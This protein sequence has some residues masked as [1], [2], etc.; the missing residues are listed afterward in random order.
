MSEDKKDRWGCPDWRDASAYPVS[1]DSLKQWAWRWQ[2]VRRLPHYRKYWVTLDPRLPKEPTDSKID[3]FQHKKPPD[4]D[5]EIIAMKYSLGLMPSPRSEGL[6]ENPFIEGIGGSILILPSLDHVL[7]E[8]GNKDDTEQFL[9]QLARKQHWMSKT[10]I[11]YIMD[12]VCLFR[13]DLNRD[14][15]KQLE[16]AERMLLY[17]QRINYPDY[18][19]ITQ[20]RENWP[21]F[22]RIIDA[23]DQ[24]PSLKL[25]NFWDQLIA[26]P[27]T[28]DKF[29]EV[30]Q[31]RARVS[32]W[33]KAASEVMEKAARLL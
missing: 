19:R 20:R 9:S 16:R 6:R 3:P 2:F 32:Q 1:G 21:L 8:C 7:S 24:E 26:D 27:E 11:G 22:L 29:I 28:C 30:N 13:F 10:D 4:E 14:I 31:P 23:W 15:K 33:R 17:I 5:G 12:S 18:E 25:D